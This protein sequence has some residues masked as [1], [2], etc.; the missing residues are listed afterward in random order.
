MNL[1]RV[2]AVSEKE[3]RYLLRD[4][5]SLGVTLL[6]PVVLL[7]LFGYAI[8]FDVK[9]IT[10]AV[11]DPDGTSTSR[12]FVQALTRTQYFDLVGGLASVTDADRV[13]AKGRAQVV[14]VIPR[15]FGADLAAGRRVD[16]QTIVDG[17]DSFTATVAMGYLD[18]IIQ[19]WARRQL[20][21]GV[22]RGA[23]RPA[24]APRLRVWFNEDLASVKFITPGLVVII[25]ML[26][27]ALLT[28][29]TIVREREQGTMEG[30]VVSPVTEKELLLG[31]LVPYVLIAAA[32]VVLVAAAGRL[33]FDVP[34]RG[35]PALALLLLLV[36]L[37]A[38]LGL[39]LLISVSAKNQQ[40]AYLVAFVGTLLP[41]ILLTG[42]IFP[43][44]SMPKAFQA[45]VQ[46][47]PATHF[48]VI[49]RAMSLKGA[50][51]IALW[52]RAAAL[53]ALAAAILGATLARFRK[54]L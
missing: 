2:W 15:R 34:L 10:L 31:K 41:T 30:L 26:L 8:N 32:D 29:Q 54:T 42:F 6:L 46:L 28:S 19:E 20:E 37:L 43:V 3:I 53:A 14:L 12:D 24:I 36:Y 50:G 16:V 49:A 7:I 44:S 40:A 38:A 52:P 48:M 1:R 22:P 17:S 18:G 5:R 35:N 23:A 39:G 33:L 4:P 45:L 25:L 47:H 13:L 51:F 21:Q 27:A 9:H 11:V